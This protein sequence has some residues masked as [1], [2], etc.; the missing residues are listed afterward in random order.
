M[1]LPTVGNEM[2]HGVYSRDMMVIIVVIMI[3]MVMMELLREIGIVQ[4]DC[5]CGD[6]GE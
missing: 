1:I 4:L 3:I 5:C 2:H 6:G